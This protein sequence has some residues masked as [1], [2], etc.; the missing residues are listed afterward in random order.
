VPILPKVTSIGLQITV[1]KNTYDFH[2]LQ[3]FL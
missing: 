2:I 3:F 1:I